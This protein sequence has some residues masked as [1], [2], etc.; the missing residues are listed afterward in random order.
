MMENGDLETRLKQLKSNGDE[1]GTQ[2]YLESLIS[3]A[4]LMLFI[5]GTPESPRC[6]FT[7][8]LLGLLAQASISD[9][10][11]FDI[12]QDDYVREQLKAYS[13]WQTYPQIYVRGQFVGGLDVLKQ[14]QEEGTLVQTL[15]V[16]V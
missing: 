6:G 4:P 16:G 3:Q 15:T 8:E 11:T 12:L 1:K 9:Y 7:K 10:K 14:M 5:K 13:S 2:P